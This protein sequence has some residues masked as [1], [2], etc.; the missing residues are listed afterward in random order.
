[1]PSDRPGKCVLSPRPAPRQTDVVVVMAQ[2][3]LAAAALSWQDRAERLEQSNIRLKNRVAEVEKAHRKSLTV[4]KNVPT[5][6][7]NHVFTKQLVDENHALRQETRALRRRLMQ[8]CTR[9]FSNQAELA[10]HPLLQE[11]KAHLRDLEVDLGRLRQE[12]ELLRRELQCQQAKKSTENKVPSS[13]NDTDHNDNI[14]NE[15]HQLQADVDA[16]LQQVKILEA[17][18]QHLE[19]KSRAKTALYHESTSRLEEVTAQ[20]FEARQQ[21]AAQAEKLQV[22]FDQTSQLDDLQQE[23][24]L[25][26]SENMTLNETITTLSSRPFDVLSK[27]LQKQNL[28]I[29]QLE[30]ENRV[31]AE[32]RGKFQADCIATKRMNDQLRR[33]VESMTAEVKNLANELSQS[34]TECEQK[35][36]EI[37]L[38]Q[39]QLR[40]YTAPDDY[41]LM[42]AVGKAIK[43]MKKQQLAKSTASIAQNTRTNI[44]DSQHVVDT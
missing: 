15:D 42:S 39:L 18:Y 19:E 27:D 23:L 30:E 26:R 17:R 5:L 11:L 37:E 35:A 2:E 12:N 28:C 44:N 33:R 24:H 8:V 43:D 29:A 10:Q 36:M 16:L 7:N 6:P 13:Q 4:V 25:L 3:A 14:N 22:Y 1:M 40:F 32:D 9:N 34:K 21:L 31:L 38:V 20:L 41:I